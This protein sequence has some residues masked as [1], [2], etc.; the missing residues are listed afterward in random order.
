MFNS[1]KQQRVEELNRLRECLSDRINS[2]DLP[3]KVVNSLLVDT[4]HLRDKLIKL[5]YYELFDLGNDNNVRLC[6]QTQTLIF[7]T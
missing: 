4:A 2:L 5:K 3:L 7:N 6:Q 1:K